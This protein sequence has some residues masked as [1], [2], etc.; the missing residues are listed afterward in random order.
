MRKLVLVIFAALSLSATAQRTEKV[1]LVPDKVELHLSKY[2]DQ[3]QT[4]K[5]F[6]IA[7]SAIQALAAGIVIANDKNTDLAMATGFIG[8]VFQMYGFF[9]VATSHRHQKKAWAAERTAIR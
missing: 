8:G 9:T 4:G 7:G 1:S 3:Y 5:A 6:M 2:K